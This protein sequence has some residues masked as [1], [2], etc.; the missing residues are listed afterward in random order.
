MKNKIY[1][2]AVLLLIFSCKNQTNK[3][4][5]IDTNSIK[6][7]TD[8]N[9]DNAH[10][11]KKSL[12]YHGTY[13]GIIPCADCEGIKTTLILDKDNSYI[14][15]IQYLGKETKIASDKGLFTWNKKGSIITITSSFGGTQ[16]YKVGEN[17]LY[18]L[19][20]K[21]TIITGDLSKNYQLTKN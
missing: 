14:R 17:I 20:K 16:M 13:K 6:T 18:H 21:G 7:E 8:Y 3:Q 10:N 4:K 9:S 15:A 11:S 5:K 2:F 12:D 1:L 19:D